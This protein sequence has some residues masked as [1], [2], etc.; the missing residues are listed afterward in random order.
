MAKQSV[1]ERIEKIFIEAQNSSQLNMKCGIYNKE[2]TEIVNRYKTQVVAWD[3]QMN[4]QENAFPSATQS[5][6]YSHYLNKKKL[7]DLGIETKCIKMRPTVYPPNQNQRLS[8]HYSHDGKNL[9]C[10]ISE[11]LLYQKN[12]YRN[13]RHIWQDGSNNRECEH[14][15]IRSQSVNGK[16]I[17][18]SCGH[19]DIIENLIDGC[20]YCHTKFHM[21]DFDGKISS[22]Y[23]PNNN[24]KSRDS[25]ML[26]KFSPVIYM[27]VVMAVLPFV[28]NKPSWGIPLTLMALI[29]FLYIFFSIA[30]KHSVSKG[31]GRNR[32]SVDKLHEVDP[33]FSEEYFIASLTNK[34]ESIHYAERM[35]EISAFTYCDLSHKIA[36]YANVLSCKLMECVITDYKSDDKIQILDV[37]VVM[38][39]AEIMGMM[40]QN[41][42]EKIR[43]R[44]AKSIESKT[45]A[46]NDII[47]YR[48]QSCGASVSLLNGGKCSYCGNSMEMIRY[49]WVVTWYDSKCS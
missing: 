7:R 16:C 38:N 33:L 26:K 8:I 25:N 6:W 35:D 21:E 27:I 24:S 41:R 14:Y 3:N 39:L 30:G 29:I 22:V 5:L 46:V 47:V 37:N 45:S 1:I 15:I 2:M 20:D 11:R 28:I 34:L 4:M 13:G 44:L 19:E 23:M 17:C 48:C 49:D 31:P 40:V 43:L 18:P 32:V 36:G 10:K 9:I 42:E 12:F